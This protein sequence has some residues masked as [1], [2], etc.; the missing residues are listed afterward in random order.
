[1]GTRE[2]SRSFGR[3]KPVEWKNESSGWEKAKIERNKR[4]KLLIGTCFLSHSYP[5]AWVPASVG[6]R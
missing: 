2:N 5:Y 4:E 3:K 6:M 1:M